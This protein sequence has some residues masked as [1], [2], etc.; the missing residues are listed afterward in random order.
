MGKLILVNKKDEIKGYEDKEKCHQG[1]GILH[2]AFAIFIF[3]DEGQLL[4]QRRSKFKKLWP[5]YWEN[6]C[7]SHP[8]K[9]EDLIKAGE[10]RLKEE[11]GLICRL[12]LLDKFQ[13]QALYKNIGAE[14]E[15]CAILV[16]KCNG[17]PKPNPKEVADWKWISLQALKKEVAKNPKK[18]APWFKIGLEKLMTL[19]TNKPKLKLNPIFNRYSKLVEP[20]IEKL[21]SQHVDKKSREAVKHQIVTG[22]KRLRP[23]LTM[24][25]CQLL[26]GKIKDALYPA[27]GLE[28]LHNYTLIIDDI[29]DNSD[30]RRGKPTCWFKFGRSIANCVA[31]DYSAALF[32]AANLAKNPVEIS[33]LFAETMK[34]IADGEILDILFEQAGREEEPYVVKNRYLNVSEK[35]YFKM[36]SKKTAS[37]FQTCCQV[38]GI[39]AGARKKEVEALKNYGFNLGV[40]FQIQDDILDIFGEEKKFGKKIGKDI[41]ERKLGNIVILFAL[42]ELSKGKKE[43]I[44]RIMRKKKIKNEDIKEAVKLINQTSAHQKA[45]QFGRKFVEKAKENLKFLPK[46]KWNNLLRETAEFSLEREE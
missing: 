21:L 36:I 11:I 20:V 12:K 9:G 26:G 6:S 25:A 24:I 14:N 44:L 45:Y 2:R 28:I 29:I 33:E 19:E 15:V 1:K 16:G 39:C 8:Q 13:Y 3:N 23:A 27:A 43:K 10:K 17:Q 5:G 46:N 41:E 4:I 30:L 31:V 22:G 37:L 38:G 42:K 18:Y 40:A 32:Q 35:D 34:T 7:S